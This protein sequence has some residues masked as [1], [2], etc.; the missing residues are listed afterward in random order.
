MLLGIWIMNNDQSSWTTQDVVFAVVALLVVVMLLVGV[1]VR[2]KW[3]SQSL[4]ADD[5]EE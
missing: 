5:K 2:R 4:P 3:S 1:D